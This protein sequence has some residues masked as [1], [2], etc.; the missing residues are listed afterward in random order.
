MLF[1]TPRPPSPT[2][3][4]TLPRFI[5]KD[6]GLQLLGN[7]ETSGCSGYNDKSKDQLRAHERLMMPPQDISFRYHWDSISRRHRTSKFR[8]LH[9]RR[10]GAPSFVLPLIS[11]LSSLFFLPDRSDCPIPY[12]LRYN[13]RIIVRPVR[14]T[15]NSIFNNARSLLRH[16]LGSN[17]KTLSLCS[18]LFHTRSTPWIVCILTFQR[19]Q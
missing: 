11:Q 8:M 4:Y 19:Q 16:P 12:L 7:P 5:L 15:S 18:C 10:C 14:R 3:H 17:S 13:V 1:G 6:P 9:T 2:I